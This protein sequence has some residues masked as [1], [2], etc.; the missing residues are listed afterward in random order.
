MSTRCVCGHPRADHRTVQM[1]VP[2][3]PQTVIYPLPAGVG[4]IATGHPT[5]TYDQQACH[6]GCTIWTPDE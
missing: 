2:L 4:T 1:S 5:A 3:T 6:C